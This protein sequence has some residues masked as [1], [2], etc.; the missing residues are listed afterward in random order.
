[1]GSRDGCKPIPPIFKWYQITCNGNV[2]T[3]I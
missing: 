2:A 3:Q 1:M